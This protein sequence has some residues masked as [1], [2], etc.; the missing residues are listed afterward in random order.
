MKSTAKLTT[1]S[2]KNILLFLITTLLMLVLSLHAY[3]TYCSINK[4]DVRILN[5]FSIVRKIYM[6]KAVIELANVSDLEASRLAKDISFKSIWDFNRSVRLY[7]ENLKITNVSVW[8]GLGVQKMVIRS[9]A[10]TER[11]L[12]KIRILNKQVAFETDKFGFKKTDFPNNEGSQAVIFLG[13]SFTEGLFA[14]PS[15]TFSNVFG[16]MMQQEGIQAIPVNM[17]VNGYSVLEMSWMLENYSKHF[18]TKMVIVNL[19]PNDVDQDF[20]KALTTDYREGYKRM[21]K[22]LEKIKAFCLAHDIKLVISVIPPKD[23]M[24]KILV[25]GLFQERVSEWCENEKV[26]FINPLEYFREMGEKNI[27][28]HWD[29]HFSGSGHKHYASYLFNHLQKELEEI[30]D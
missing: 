5:N 11:L 2:I 4:K 15:L 25:D 6:N 21:F 26:I 20:I 1:S 3:I 14:P 7:K 8:T 23:Q 12:K 27:Y 17:G 9:D 18:D 28:F 10:E 30:I 29:P 19:F 24:T 16:T 22:Y 13:D